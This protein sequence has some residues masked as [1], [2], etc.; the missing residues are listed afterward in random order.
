MTA[1]TTGFRPEPHGRE[2]HSSR[3]TTLSRPDGGQLS[4]LSIMLGLLSIVMFWM[5]G[6][7]IPLGAGAI[8]AGIAAHRHPTVEGNESKALEAL[9]GVL[10]GAFGI[11][12]GL[13]FLAAALPNL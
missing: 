13:V 1:P 8:A 11:A 10:A 7:G 5:F 4:D 3:T 6:F 9:L 12:A 2:P